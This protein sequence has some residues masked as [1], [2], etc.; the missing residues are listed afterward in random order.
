MKTEERNQPGG[1]LRV[2][3]LR[4]DVEREGQEVDVPVH[5]VTDGMHQESAQ[6][7]SCRTGLVQIFGG[8]PKFTARVI[9]AGSKN[10]SCYKTWE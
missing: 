10:G 4:I 7:C 5:F 1:K 6:Q 3:L 8:V 9:C 2:I